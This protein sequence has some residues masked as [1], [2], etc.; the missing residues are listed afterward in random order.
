MRATKYGRS[1]AVKS[2]ELTS[3]KMADGGGYLSTE[4]R[5]SLLVNDGSPNVASPTLFTYETFTPELVR[6][7][8]AAAVPS[9]ADGLINLS[10]KVETMNET[11]SKV[12]AFLR[13]SGSCCWP[14]S[15]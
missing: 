10:K 5:P 15:I 7:C 13:N 6:G 11:F 12:I 2:L 8:S 4:R 14:H 1:A 9:S 3:I